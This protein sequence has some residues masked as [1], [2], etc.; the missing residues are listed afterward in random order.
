MAFYKDPT[1]GQVIDVTNEALNPD[2][3][4]GKTKVADASGAINSTNLAP[5]TDI[6]YETPN[7]EPVVAPPPPVD[8]QGANELGTTETELAKLIREGMAGNEAIAGKSAFQAEQETAQGLPELQ[9]TQKQLIAQ[10]TGLSNEALAIPLQIQQE[11]AG[12][13]ATAGGVAPIQTGRLRENAIKALSVNSLL[14]ASQGAIAT[15]N[16]FVDRAVKAKFGPLEEAQ[17]IRIKNLELLKEDPNITLEQKKRADAQTLIQEA[18]KAKL[19]QQKENYQIGQAMAAAAVKNNPGNQSAI[20]AAQQLQALNPTD[21]N[22][23]QKVYSLVGQY[24]SDPIQA[25][26]DLFELSYKQAQ[27]ESMRE[28]TLLAREKFQE[29]VRQHGMD[30]ALKQQEIDLKKSDSVTG[31]NLTVDQAKARQFAIAASNAD[32]VLSSSVYKLGNV[33]TWIPN[34]LKSNERQTFEQAARAFV[35]A[36]LRRES[37]ATITDS[38]FKSKY[39]ELIPSA[40][41]GADVI[42]QKKL[43]RGAAVQSI[44]E[45]GL[46]S[47][48]SNEDTQIANGVTYVKGADGLYYPK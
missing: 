29:D 4:A 6:K 11:F 25:Q 43:A 31:K 46:L 17:A 3:I 45:A 7:P 12:R 8:T 20:L 18:K 22:Y 32:S 47:P 33:E 24:Q 19:E 23:L 2:L 41:D 14:A 39:R 36:T 44:Q 48:T 10:L 38:E 1:T 26:K 27:I 34:A 42:A 9:K 5:Q 13:G 15:A 21:P 35:N 28:E 37:G 30:Y 40:G 16:D